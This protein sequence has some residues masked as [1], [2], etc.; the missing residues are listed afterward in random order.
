MTRKSILMLVLYVTAGLALLA[1][2]LY[3]VLS[4]VLRPIIDTGESFMAAVRD[5]DMR[6]AYAL[7]TPALQQ[8]VGDQAGMEATIGNHRPRSWS[9][10]QRK[11]RNGIGYLIGSA[12]FG[13]A[14]E[15][16]VSLELR[17]VDGEW[18]IDSF[19]FN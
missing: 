5:G 7:S 8:R 2:I 13:G 4:A 14:G 19:R 6:R 10:S 11:N 12:D 1:G 15:G 16:N 17:G 3:F 9:W 18:R